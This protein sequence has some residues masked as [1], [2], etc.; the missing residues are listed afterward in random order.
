MQQVQKPAPQT[1]TVL[2]TLILTPG[3]TRSATEPPRLDL[4]KHVDTVVLEPV[5]EGNGPFSA[6]IRS[7]ESEL[8]SAM[9]L[10]RGNGGTSG[11]A[12]RPASSLLRVQVPARLFATGDHLLTLRD[13]GGE[14]IDDY[15]FSVIR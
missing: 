13:A 10:T 15:L 14:V 7:G 3:V 2:V 12:S 9:G 1:A 8:W 5:V 11:D 4:R 6:T